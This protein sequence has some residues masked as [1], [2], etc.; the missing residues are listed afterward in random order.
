MRQGI[1]IM[2]DLIRLSGETI[3]IIT[4]LMIA[5]ANC[6]HICTVVYA[7]EFLLHAIRMQL[8]VTTKAYP[9]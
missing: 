2:H 6:L 1:V 8:L 3:I 7:V 9:H 4:V 5:Q